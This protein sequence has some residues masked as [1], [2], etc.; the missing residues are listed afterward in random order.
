[1][2]ITSLDD[3]EAVVFE[4]IA[5]AEASARKRAEE[6]KRL[7]EL[8]LREEEEKRKQ[9]IAELNERLL[10]EAEDRRRAEDAMNTLSAK[11]QQLAKAQATAE[12]RLAALATASEYGGEE[13]QPNAEVEK[14]RA[15]LREKEASLKRLAMERREMEERY[16]DALARQ[17]ATATEIIEEGRGTKSGRDLLTYIVD[18]IEYVLSTGEEDSKN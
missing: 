15:E 4:R 17:S 18:L 2:S 5:A 10:Q 6:A 1:M 3:G 11:M 13:T 16:Q 8:K 9:R 12:D 14:L 7:A